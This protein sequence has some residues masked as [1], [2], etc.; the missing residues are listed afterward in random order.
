MK[1]LFLLFL[2]LFTVSIN[3]QTFLDV[4][5]SGG[6]LN[7]TNLN[8]IQKIT[9]SS[10][11]INFVLTDNSTQS[12]ALSTINKITFSSNDGGNPLPVELISFSASINDD[13]VMLNWVTAV[14][15]SNYGFE[16]EKAEVNDLFEKIGFVEGKGNSNSPQNYSFTDRPNKGIKLI[17]RLKQIDNDGKYKYSNIIEVTITIPAQ[18]ELKQNYP[19]PFNPATTIVY[20]I[21][22]NGLVTLKVYDILGN[23][24]TKLVNENQKAGSYEI[25][26]DGSKLA[27]GFYI[28][29]LNSGNYSSSIKMLL[30][31]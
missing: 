24:I 9:F 15:I 23:E 5:Y 13:E 17:Y 28:C 12:K 6:L 3:A 11:D 29:R 10:N 31:K 4:S 22:N 21:P 2:F 19:N 7:S 27:S 26:F 18:Y 14:E 25:I 16:I 1:K 8:L 30:L 20:N